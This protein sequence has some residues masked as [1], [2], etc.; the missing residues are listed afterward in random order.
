MAD[1]PIEEYLKAKYYLDED[2]SSLLEG[3]AATPQPEQ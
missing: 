1:K 3:G 2:D